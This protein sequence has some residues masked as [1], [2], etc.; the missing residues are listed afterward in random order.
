MNFFLEVI[1]FIDKLIIS[2]GKSNVQTIQNCIVFQSNFKA[3]TYIIQVY[4]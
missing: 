1:M 3:K 4:I 2:L